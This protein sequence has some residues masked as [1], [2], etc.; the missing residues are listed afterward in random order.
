MPARD[1]LAVE[2]LSLLSK[3][4]HPVVVVVLSRD[5]PLGFNELLDAIP[6]V[7]GKVLTETLETLRES[8]L[9]E[10]REL[11]ESPLRVEYD[12][13]AAGRD[14][15]PVFDALADWGERHLESATPVVLLADADRRITELYGGWLSARYAVVRAHD[16]DEL[17]ER[18]DESVDVVLLD[19]RLPGTDARE[20]VSGLASACRTVLLVGDRPDV[21]LLA[22]GYDDVL[23]KPVVR[24]TAIQAIDRQLSRRGEPPERRERSSLEAR[25]SLYESIYPAERLAATAAYRDCRERLRELDDRHGE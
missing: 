7:S 2:T 24:E 8:G 6:D 18:F 11:S 25:L 22:G 3:K 4:W 23:R 16:G 20:F 21:D 14:M 1:R 15:E 19:E 13:T 17:D 12:L 9:V 10:R 5:G